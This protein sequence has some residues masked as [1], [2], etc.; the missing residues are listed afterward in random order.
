MSINKWNARPSHIVIA[1]KDELIH[2]QK[3]ELEK[4][5]FKLAELNEYEVSLKILVDDATC[6]HLLISSN[7]CENCNF[8]R[9][10]NCSKATTRFRMQK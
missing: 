3:I 2:N 6:Q 4:L 7:N 9:A 5:S 1:E 8:L 10:E